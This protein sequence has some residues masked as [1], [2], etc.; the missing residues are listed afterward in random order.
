[1]YLHLLKISSIQSHSHRVNSLLPI[2]INPLLA[3]VN[4]V[5]ILLGSFKTPRYPFSLDLT[6]LRMIISFAIPYESS[7]GR[8]LMVKGQYLALIDELDIAE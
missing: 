1:M 7:L 8:R 2:I 4:A 6:Q 5:F 3:L